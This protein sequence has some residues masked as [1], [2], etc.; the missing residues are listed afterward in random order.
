MN[1]QSSMARALHRDR[2][3][4]KNN[5]KYTPTNPTDRQNTYALLVRSEDKEQN[6]SETVVYML[7]IICAT[8]S[9]WFAAH[10]PVR[11]PVGAV[12]HTATAAQPAAVPQPAV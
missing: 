3:L 1:Y 5:M 4:T 7:L 10:Q 9:M 6:V 11:L 8:F 12:I 2:S